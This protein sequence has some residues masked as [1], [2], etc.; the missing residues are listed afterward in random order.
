MGAANGEGEV[1]VG[2]IGVRSAQP[3]MEGDRA[4]GTAASAGNARNV[5]SSDRTGK[6]LQDLLSLPPEERAKLMET[7]VG[8]TSTA[9]GAAKA[10]GRLSK[11]LNWITSFL[12]ATKPVAVTESRPDAARASQTQVA[13]PKDFVQAASAPATARPAAPTA[14]VGRTVSVGA[15]QPRDTGAGTGLGAAFTNEELIACFDDATEANVC[16]RCDDEFP[17]AVYSQEA[18]ETHVATCSDP[19]RLTLDVPESATAVP[20]NA[21]ADGGVGVPVASALAAGSPKKAL[22]VAESVRCLATFIEDVW[23]AG[24]G[25]KLWNRGVAVAEP[26]IR[27][28]P[29]SMWPIDLLPPA[30]REP[31][32][33][34]VASVLAAL[35]WYLTQAPPGTRLPAAAAD[36][37]AA[38]SG[39]GGRNRGS[40]PP[41]DYAFAL[42]RDGSL[43]TQIFTKTK[44]AAYSTAGVA[45][46]I[47]ARQ[48]D[49]T[50]HFAK[51]HLL[52]HYMLRAV[53]GRMVAGMD[54]RTMLMDRVSFPSNLDWTTA[55]LAAVRNAV[56]DVDLSDLLVFTTVSY[57]VDRVHALKDA[58]G[59]AEIALRDAYGDG[60][61]ASS[62]LRWLVHSETRPVDTLYG[63]LRRQAMG[64]D[65][66]EVEAAQVAADTVRTRLQHCFAEWR[67]SAVIRLEEW[68]LR[69]NDETARQPVLTLAVPPPQI[70][71][72]A[73][74][75]HQS[76]I[77]RLQVA[78]TVDRSD[79]T[80]AVL[81]RAKRVEASMTAALQRVTIGA[82]RGGGTGAGRGVG[83]PRA[84]QVAASGRTDRPPTL[85]E[86]SAGR[87]PAEMME[88]KREADGGT[89]TLPALLAA[90]PALK[91]YTYLGE[92]MCWRGC[93][94]GCVHPTCRYSHPVLLL[95]WFGQARNGSVDARREFLRSMGVA[96]ADAPAA[97]A[98][99]HKPG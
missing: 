82:A 64:V 34:E 33:A 61:P 75:P 51:K 90:R 59:N 27:G 98:V 86:V 38:V 13:R 20:L 2:E 88:V 62:A 60:H 46:Y 14:G 49:P 79:E 71:D 55:R 29:P 7:A 30:R 12:A 1:Q 10:D 42:Q 81:L 54:A 35:R 48:F 43:G 40:D 47:G 37:V 5:T 89:V 94:S 56:C 85:I 99:N 52:H 26:F 77:A 50:A 84:P 45:G 93:I 73:G 76:L 28:L 69:W 78:C 32:A 72:S 3:R 39:T 21:D 41:S 36:T 17:K 31:K 95:K 65:Y 16:P 15:K 87:L 19:Y 23:Y 24:G 91:N 68:F 70:V 83:S 8:S 92:P 44:V 6:L 4:V 63:E 74:A 66:S 9:T 96:V 11:T 57:A 80:F 97:A 25:T 58:L 53:D 22:S 67:R 18:F